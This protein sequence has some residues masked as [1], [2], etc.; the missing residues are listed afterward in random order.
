MTDFYGIVIK[1]GSEKTAKVRIER[2]YMHPKYKKRIKLFAKLSVH[3][4][5]G[6]KVGDKV[7]VASTKP[8]SKTKKHVIKSKI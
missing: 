7:C 2:S 6:V 8:I 4:D 3:D 5:L 1:V